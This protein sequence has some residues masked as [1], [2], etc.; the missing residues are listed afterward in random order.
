MRLR[1]TMLAGGISRLAFL[2][3]DLTLA[4]Q[5]SLKLGSDFFSGAAFERIGT[6]A[7]HHRE[8]DHD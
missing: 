7:E 8:A 1:H 4:G 3:H 5:T 2:R 6:T